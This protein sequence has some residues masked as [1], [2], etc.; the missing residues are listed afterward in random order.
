MR[1]SFEPA[2]IFLYPEKATGLERG[3]MKGRFAGLMLACVVCLWGAFAAPFSSAEEQ[4][5]HI[6]LSFG[7]GEYEGNHTDPWINESW[8][9]GAEYEAN[10]TF[11]FNLTVEN[12]ASESTDVYVLVAVRGNTTDSD[13]QTMAVEG[14]DA[15][16]A[17]YTLADFDRTDYNP[18]YL[19]QISAGSHGVYP[20]S[21]NGIWVTY[22]AGW[23]DGKGTGNNVTNLTIDVTLGPDP[24]DI[25]VVHFDAY[26]LDADGELKYW[27]PN[28][29]DS[30]VVK[31]EEKGNGKGKGKGKKPKK[32]QGGNEEGPIEDPV[33]PPVED[34]PEDPTPVEEPPVVED[35]DLPVEEPDTPPVEDP[36]DPV[37]DEGPAEGETSETEDPILPVQEDETGDEVETP[38]IDPLVEDDIPGGSDE[39]LATEPESS[40]GTDA[41]IPAGALFALAAALLVLVALMRRR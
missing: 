17:V 14:G 28:G 16:A 19:D 3:S 7:D 37:P 22:R 4:G 6:W 26:G 8:V 20:P 5:G 41:T 2:E 24:S 27:S 34:E 29:H 33:E 36:E 25:F 39:T 9:V 18:F 21:G 15:G 32:E 1:L 13:M 12:R 10:G 30:T 40:D 38:L 11:Q 31:K 23:V 35:E